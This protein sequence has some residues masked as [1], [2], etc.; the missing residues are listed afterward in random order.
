MV[1]GEFLR[2]IGSEKLRP[3]ILGNVGLWET[4]PKKEEKGMVGVVLVE[5]AFRGH[6]YNISSASM[7]NIP[8]TE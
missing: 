1:D 2:R 6:M 3:N 4:K 7:S 8:W 5:E